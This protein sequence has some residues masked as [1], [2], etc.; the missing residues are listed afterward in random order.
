MQGGPRS[1]CLVAAHCAAVPPAC[2]ARFARW[3]M[4]VFLLRSI[5]ECVCTPAPAAMRATLAALPAAPHRSCTAWTTRTATRWGDALHPTRP[6]G[7]SWTACHQ[8]APTGELPHMPE[9]GATGATAPAQR[10]TGLPA[11]QPAVAQHHRPRCLLV[12][13]SGGS[14]SVSALTAACTFPSAPPAT[15]AAKAATSEFFMKGVFAGTGC[16][17]GNG[18]PPAS[19]HLPHTL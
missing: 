2:R 6:S 7:W 8:P 12:S 1:G 16:W 10:Y 4:S 13:K 17:E 15:P 3:R 18:D 9:Q 14:S 5:L 19:S 11:S